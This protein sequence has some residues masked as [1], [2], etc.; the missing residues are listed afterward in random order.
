MYDAIIIGA[1]A[2]GC[3]LA[4]RLAQR[5]KMSV[6]LLEKSL[7]GVEASSAAAGMLGAQ[8]EAHTSGP[9]LDFCLYSRSLYPAFAEE[10]F[11]QTEIHIG[12]RECGILEIACSEKDAERL[13]G[14]YQWQKERHLEIEM[15]DPIE[16]LQMEP[17]LLPQNHGAL[18]Y[19]KDHQVDPLLLARAVSSA[20]H[21]V[22][23]HFLT[24]KMV[25]QLLIQNNHIQGVLLDGEKIEGRFVFVT[26]GAW[27]SQ[28]PSLPPLRSPIRPIRGQMAVFDTRPPLV[29]HTLV[30]SRGYLVPRADGRILVGSTMESAGFQKYVTAGGLLH[31]CTLAIE[32][33]PSLKEA[34]LLETWA[35]F[36]PSSDDG[37]PLIGPTSIKGLWIASGHHRN[38]I[39]LLPGTVELILAQIKGESLPW[40]LSAFLPT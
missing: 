39:L 14:R 23:V 6:L 35:G 34:P 36:R 32:M 25:Q 30:S 17:H 33:V 31:L 37:L 26:A 15:L 16:L 2:M 10:L 28:I 24:G 27:T 9:F 19:P 18:F 20:A 11:Q 13:I 5:E 38:G 1:G 22:G 8:M 7:P 21:Q 12:Y 29:R 4:Y 3:T 40:D